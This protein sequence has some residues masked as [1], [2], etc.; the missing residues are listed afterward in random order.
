ML[1]SD[2]NI[3]ELLDLFFE[4][5]LDTRF[6]S[7]NQEPGIIPDIY[8][9]LGRICSCQIHCDTILILIFFSY[10]VMTLCG[11]DLMFL[12]RIRGTN[13][14]KREP[15]RF[16]EATTMRIGVHALFAIKVSLHRQP[17][18]RHLSIYSMILNF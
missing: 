15:D 12:K 6:D 13:D 1:G 16:S 4:I 3:G 2:K 7:S 18:N 10:I 17:Q 8:P 14:I 11:P 9:K 5:K